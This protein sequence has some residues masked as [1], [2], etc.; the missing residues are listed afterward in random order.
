MSVAGVLVASV[1]EVGL[2]LRCD[3]DPSDEA[4]C[5]ILGLTMESCSALAERAY[6]VID[7]R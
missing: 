5:S 4:H 3:D 7:N 2:D 1:Y 6:L